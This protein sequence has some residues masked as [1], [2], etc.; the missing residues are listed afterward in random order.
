ME[1]RSFIRKGM[2]KIFDR[3]FPEILKR[4]LLQK[5][6]DEN[7]VVE[8]VLDKTAERDPRPTN[9]LFPKIF[10]LSQL[11]FGTCSKENLWWI[12]VKVELQSIHCRPTSLL[13]YTPSQTF[14]WE[15]SKLP[16]LI[17]CRSI[18]TNNELLNFLKVF[19]K[20]RKIIRNCQP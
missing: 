5:P 20:F 12:L 14:P 15:F 7:S 18:R 8:S 6:Y 17:R 3:K 11:S 10:F 16:Q 1:A 13:E 2:A 9:K 4:A 19:W